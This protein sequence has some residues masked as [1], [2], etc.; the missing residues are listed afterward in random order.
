MKKI[1]LLSILFLFTSHILFAQTNN[2]K[3]IVVDQETNKPIEAVSIKVVGKSTYTYTDAKGQFSIE[4]AKNDFIELDHL[5]YQTKKVSVVTSASI[6]LSQKKISLDEIV[7][8]SHPLDDISHS[9]VVI[10][11]VKRG[12]QARNVAELFN[13]ISGF[14]IQKRS[15][16]ASEPSFR[17]FKYEQMNIKIDGGTK[18]VHAC[19][20]R[21]DP[22]TAHLIPEEVS[23]IEVIKG[24]FSVRFGQSFGPIVNLVTKTPTPDDYGVHGSLQSGYES[25]GNSFVGRAELL[26]VHE[27]FDVTIN[28]ENRNFGD[29]TDG[30]GILTP[31]AFKTNSYSVKAAYKPTNEQ[32]LQVDWRQKFGKDIMHAGLPMDSPLDDSN[33]LAL[34]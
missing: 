5:A 10:D 7:I 26:Y 23:K 29:Y 24:P 12:S 6:S 34:D 9:I 17:A 3:G 18:I 13:D 1:F 15:A 20:N 25:N 14:S 31:A 27:K 28:G 32:R 4:A 11:E 21:M 30:N 8:K 19:P 33:S 16:T 2:Y 22:I